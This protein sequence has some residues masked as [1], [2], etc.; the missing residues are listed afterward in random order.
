MKIRNDFVSNSSSCSFIIDAK[1]INLMQF[2]VDQQ[3]S[4]LAVPADI[5]D[6]IRIRIYA[7]NKN[8]N[9]LYANLEH[10]G[11][12]KP[13]YDFSIYEWTKDQLEDLS[14]SSIELSVGEFIGL[15]HS[16]DEKTLS[17]IEQVMF[18]TD[19]YGSGPANLKDF[20]D[21]FKRNNC[22][23]NADDSEHG[24]IDKTTSKFKNVLRGM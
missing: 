22:C 1:R 20:Y 4:D 6:D 14:W 12:V 21:F 15:M 19:D 10:F 18:E 11:Y 5:C 23:P 13:G 24:F 17:L 16:V 2:A 9:E 8:V 3:L 7:K